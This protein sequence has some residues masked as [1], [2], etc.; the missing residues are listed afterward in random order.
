MLV[1]HAEVH[2]QMRTQHVQL[3]VGALHVH[4][5]RVADFFEQCFDQTCRTV[6]FGHVQLRRHARRA[7]GQRHQT[8]TGALVQGFQQR[9]DFV[10]QHA[11]HQPLAALV[12]DLVQY[13]QRHGHGHA[14]FGVA[15]F[16]QVGGLAVHA[17]QAYGFGERLGGDAGS[18]VAHQL[19]A[20]Q[21]QQLRLALDFFAIP[22]LKTVA[23]AHVGGQLLVVKGVDQLVVHQHVLP[24]GFVFQLFD[25]RDQLLVGRKEWQFG[26]PVVGH[27]RLAD[28]NLARSN[29]VDA[30]KVYF[31]SAVN[32]QAIE[33]GSLQRDDFSGFFLP[34]R[35]QQLLFEQMAGDFFQPLR[36]DIRQTPT[37]QARG[38]DQF[39][40]HD[41]APGLFG[42]MRA[43]VGE[44]LDAACAQVFATLPFFLP[45]AGRGFGLYLPADVAQQPRQHGQVQLFIAGRLCI[46]TPFVFRHD[47]DQLAVDVTPLAHAAD[48]DEVLA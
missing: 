28:E 26:F 14:V 38:F 4:L 36:L 48:V 30:T 7:F 23:A 25:L 19:V 29:H 20:G 41:P 32:N 22:V 16:V 37:K 24:T 1:H 31:S 27:Q 3:E 45:P 34:M 9:L 33:R 39:G 21:H 35:I 6:S 46:N 13:K 18:L 17:A 2:E 44:E 40:R 15:G 11:G 5:R 12:V 10:F 43:G 8:R 42:Q 47:G